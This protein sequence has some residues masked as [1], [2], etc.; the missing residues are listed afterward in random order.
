[1][2]VNWNPPLHFGPLLHFTWKPL[3]F[4][5]LIFFAQLFKEN[6]TK[7]FLSFSSAFGSGV[8]KQWRHIFLSE[9]FVLSVSKSTPT[10]FCRCVVSFASSAAMAILC[11]LIVLARCLHHFQSKGL[12]R[13]AQSRE[14]I[15]AGQ[16][17][18]E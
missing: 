17:D 9:L 15:Q 12:R 5:K 4:L 11:G 16:E 18:L 3:L 10:L 8:E 14:R 13:S 7:F 2:T 6:T 1:M